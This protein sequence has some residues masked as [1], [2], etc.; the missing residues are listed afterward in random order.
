MTSTSERL[1]GSTLARCLSVRY[2]VHSAEATPSYYELT[3]I[4][5]A[6]KHFQQVVQIPPHIWQAVISSEDASFF[7]HPGLDING[8]ARALLSLGRR[9][10]GSTITQ[11]LIK[12]HL[13]SNSP[14]MSR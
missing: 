5:V 6:P 8:M 3:G 1:R 2:A 11:Q 14:T 7:R 10:G 13:L 9:G 4:Q 12:N